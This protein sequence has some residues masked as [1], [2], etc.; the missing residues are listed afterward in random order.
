MV[1][2]CAPLSQGDVVV[3]PGGAEFEVVSTPGNFDPSWSLSFLGSKH[4][5]DWNPFTLGGPG[6]DLEIP[7]WTGRTAELELAQGSLF[8][9]GDGVTRLDGEEAEI[10]S[11]HRLAKGSRLA[12]GQDGVQVTVDFEGTPVTEVLP[13]R[14]L[15]ER[16]VVESPEGRRGRATF[17]FD[18]IDYPVELQ[19]QHAQVLGAVVEL[20]K[21]CRVDS[22]VAIGFVPSSDGRQTPLLANQDIIRKAWPRRVGSTPQ[23]LTTIFCRLNR[24]L[25]AHGID[26]YSLF[27]RKQGGTAIHLA[28]GA[29]LDQ[30]TPPADPS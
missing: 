30:F 5:I 10:G 23:N 3:V 17:T 26:G 28:P 24:D 18:G 14:L 21:E 12:A 2:D 29:I 4:Y 13:V 8:L 1:K 27:V 9:V 19:E 22:S 11:S 6:A 16:L 20:R 25:V 7:G 15:P